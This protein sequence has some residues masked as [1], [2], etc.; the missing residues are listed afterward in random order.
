MKDFHEAAKQ[1]DYVAPVIEYQQFKNVKK[2]YKNGHAV[3]ETA[4]EILKDERGS[5]RIKWTSN[6]VE[7][8]YVLFNKT[9]KGSVPIP[10]GLGPNGGRLQSHHGLQQQWAKENLT[11]YGYDPSLA[12][13]VTI[14]TG[15]GLPHTIISTAQNA[16]RNA[17][18]AQGKG[19]WSSTL[20]E[21]LQY[22]Y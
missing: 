2:A 1:L 22:I 4:K 9:H 6:L 11:K 20:Q 17:R 3:V 15:K 18:V 8:N 10:K 16:R 13:T 19:K 5:V 21:E 12:P 7:K 14:E